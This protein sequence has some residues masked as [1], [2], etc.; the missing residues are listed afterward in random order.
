MSYCYCY[1]D[2][3][4]LLGTKGTSLLIPIQGNALPHSR[5]HSM[6]PSHTTLVLCIHLSFI[7]ILFIFT[8]LSYLLYAKVYFYT[9]EKSISFP[10]CP[11]GTE[12][13]GISVPTGVRSLRPHC[14]HHIKSSMHLHRA[15]TW[16][17]L[18]T[19]Y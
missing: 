4:T 8:S 3:G 18:I 5:Q 15:D 1:H 7:S 12:G 10:I 14:L 11:L 2:R 9:R 17:F 13:T 19:L 16:N 6:D